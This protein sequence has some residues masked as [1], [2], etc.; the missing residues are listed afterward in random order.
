MLGGYGPEL[1]GWTG[2]PDAHAASSRATEPA[3]AGYPRSLR[4]VVLP[5]LRG[6]PHSLARLTVGHFRPYA[7]SVGWGEAMKIAQPLVVAAV[8]SAGGCATVPKEPER[9]SVPVVAVP[10]AAVLPATPTLKRKVAVARFTNSTRYGKSL[11]SDGESDPLADQA[12]DMLSSRLVDSRQFIVFERNDL[13]AVAA[14]NQLMKLDVTANLVGV[15]ALIVGSVTEFGRAVEGQ[16]G[17]LSST[18]RQK[19]SATVE[20]RLVDPRS[21]LVI[22]SASGKGEATTESG[23]VAGF[24]SQ[25]GY[26]A[27]LNDAAISAAIS[28]LTSEL[29]GKLSSRR[30][31]TDILR[32]DGTRIFISGGA[33]Q[34]LKPGDRLAVET[35]GE[36][37]RSAQ[38]G[39][40]IT[41]PGERIATIEVNDFFGDDEY[42]EGSSATVVEGSI[43]GRDPS[44]LVVVE[45]K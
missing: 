33:R 23:E 41:L 27:R 6:S 26:D 15:D 7:G 12:A 43:A 40:P 28:D 24:G 30:W 13:A 25:A 1:P 29:I 8:L 32:M 36:T 31:S 42:S 21:G 5:T 39:L 18:K 20:A 9:V 14:E 2:E 17:F 35:R 11:L 38:T 22:F 44:T 34:G 45:G 19:A 10:A 3:L 37:V 16:S 4:G